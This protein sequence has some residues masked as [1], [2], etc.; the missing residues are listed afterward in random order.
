METEKTDTLRQTARV[1]IQGLL[2]RPAV[3]YSNSRTNLNS[4]PSSDSLSLCLR[5][6]ANSD[7]LEIR[8]ETLTGQDQSPMK[9]ERKKKTENIGALSER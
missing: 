2:T 1:S 4:Q 6:P 3:C 8:L 5:I 7:H 9:K